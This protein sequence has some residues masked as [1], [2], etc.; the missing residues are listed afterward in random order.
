MLEQQVIPRLLA[1]TGA[2]ASIHL[3]R[4]HSYGLGE[5]HV[6]Q[7]LAGVEAS[8][9]KVASNWVSAPITRNWKPS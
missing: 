8:T 3:K 7:I 9:P 1:R 4:F 6:D 5:S 2:P